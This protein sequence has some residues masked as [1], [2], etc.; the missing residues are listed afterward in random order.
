MINK[1]T[2]FSDF[3]I[4]L[5]GE[6]DSL[7]SIM[8]ILSSGVIRAVSAFGYQRDWHSANASCFSE[9]PP[10]HLKKLVDRRSIHGIA[11]KKEFMIK[12]GAQRVWYIDKDTDLEQQIINLSI[13]RN[14]GVSES[15]KSIFPFI[16]IVGFHGSSRYEFSWEREWRILGDLFFQPEDVAFLIIPKSHHE[17]AKEFFYD[18]RVE[19]LGPS[20]TC[21]FYDPLFDTYTN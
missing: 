17:S 10:K 13:E 4:H 1:N 19:S 16:D 8:G 14:D 15:L 3:L 18:A 7:N 11:F 20:Y 5:A 9:I 21:P 6:T 2:D 12:S